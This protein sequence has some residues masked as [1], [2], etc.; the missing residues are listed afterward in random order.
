LV[1]KPYTLWYNKLGGNMTDIL[2]NEEKIDIINSHKKN[3]AFNEFN[4]QI[5]LVEENSKSNP[6][7]TTVNNLNNQI[8]DVQNQ[9]SV[10]DA[11]IQKLTI[12]NQ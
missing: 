2:T 8:T 5:T 6:N 10:L 11:E 3:I 1:K 4:L 12:V 7:E 9:L